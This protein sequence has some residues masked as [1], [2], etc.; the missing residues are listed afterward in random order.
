MYVISTSVSRRSSYSLNS[1]SII[2][3]YVANVGKLQVYRNVV[4]NFVCEILDGESGSRDY[5]DF[6]V[7]S[8]ATAWQKLHADSHGVL[9][10]SRIFVAD[11]TE[12][13]EQD[14]CNSDDA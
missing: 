4:L 7:V 9:V 3:F 5:L 12:S 8:A 2:N 1:F 10:P 11:G 13:R 14:D 6:R